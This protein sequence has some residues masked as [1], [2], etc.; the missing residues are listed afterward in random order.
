MPDDLRVIIA[1]CLVHGRRKFVE[2]VEAFPD[3]V[4]YL[5]RCL[6]KVYQTDAQ[7][8]QQHLSPDE[9]LKL[10]QEQSGPVMDELHRWLEWQINE[11]LVEPNSA[12]GKAISYMLKY[13]EKLTCFLRV[14][15]APLDNNVC[16][17]ALKMAIRH[18]KNS[19]FYRSM[20]GASVGDLYMSLIYSCY[21]AVVSPVHYLTALLRNHERVRAVP[22]EWMPWNYQQQLSG[23]KGE[24]DGG[25][26]SPCDTVLPT[27]RSPC[28]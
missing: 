7:A 1:N 19:Y 21:L 6:K 20:R 10:H 4:K 15:G 24:S 18:R 9:R 27:A 13:W 22:G 8:K 2:I 3:E 26:G 12:L 16:E 11:K 17:R 5:L 25:G 14:P 28:A 23:T